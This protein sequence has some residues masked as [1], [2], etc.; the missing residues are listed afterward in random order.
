MLFRSTKVMEVAT[1]PARKRFLVLSGRDMEDLN[2]Q[3]Q[4]L[5]RTLLQLHSGGLTFVD[6]DETRKPF[7][8]RWLLDYVISTMS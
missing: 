2:N 1:H 3:H 8:P 4:F 5:S 6:V 7:L